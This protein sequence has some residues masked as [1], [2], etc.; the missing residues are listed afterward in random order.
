MIS[1]FSKSVLSTIQSYPITTCTDLKNS[2]NCDSEAEDVKSTCKLPSWLEKKDAYVPPKYLYDTYEKKTCCSDLTKV[3]DNSTYR[4]FCKAFSK[5]ANGSRYSSSPYYVMPHYTGTMGYYNDADL[6]K[7]LKIKGNS[8][9]WVVIHNIKTG[10]C[11]VVDENYKVWQTSSDKD[12]TNPPGI[13][14][15]TLIKSDDIMGNLYE[16]H[17]RIGVGG[18]LSE[19]GKLTT[20]FPKITPDKQTMTIEF[21]VHSGTK[22]VNSGDQVI[23]IPFSTDSKKYFRKQPSELPERHKGETTYDFVN[24]DMNGEKFNYY[25]N[26]IGGDN[27]FPS[28]VTSFHSR[29]TPGIQ[30]WLRYETKNRLMGRMAVSS[31]NAPFTTYDTSPLFWESVDS[32]ETSFSEFTKFDGWKDDPLKQFK[33]SLASGKMNYTIQE[34]RNLKIYYSEIKFY[35]KLNA[36]DGIFYRPVYIPGKTPLRQNNMGQIYQA[37]TTVDVDDGDCEESGC[38]H[39]I[40]VEIDFKNRKA[41]GF[42]NGSP[43][44]TG[45]NSI[46]F[47]KAQCSD[48]KFA[49]YNFMLTDYDP[50]LLN[51]GDTFVR[52]D[53]VEM[54]LAPRYESR[55]EDCFFPID[56]DFKEAYAMYM[57]SQ[58]ISDETAIADLN[59]TLSS[60]ELGDLPVT[61]MFPCKDSDS[62]DVDQKPCSES[63]FP[64]DTRYCLG[65]SRSEYKHFPY[66]VGDKDTGCNSNAYKGCLDATYSACPL[67]LALTCQNAN[68]PAPKC[69]L[70][71]GKNKD[72]VDRYGRTCADISNDKRYCPGSS[73][74]NWALFPYKKDSCDQNNYAG[75]ELTIL[76]ACTETFGEFC[77]DEGLPIKSC[78]FKCKDTNMVDRKNRDCSWLASKNDP[79][80]CKGGSRSTWYE[81]PLVEGKCKDSNYSGCEKTWSEMCPATM[82]TICKSAGLTVNDNINNCH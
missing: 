49:A 52:E 59:I 68:K 4:S 11:K 44:C 70:P 65:T 21:Y 23:E 53:G 28:G 9:D 51:V 78:T 69:L 34:A 57:G 13:C 27:F 81:G 15:R 42:L 74:E 20:L 64:K 82:H 80:Y 55:S 2:Y 58:S 16:P 8:R 61:T 41:R 50:P 3:F 47:G 26:G 46:C 71:C 32:N 31:E 72:V 39:K 45:R 35:H 10:L 43:I 37:K 14:D 73:R 56:D 19:S 60:D 54:T 7:P 6:M 29:R 67:T 30:L 33:D 40:K 24:D 17:V 77:R 62:L 12:P 5:H 36:S 79:R 25:E 18:H 22:G 48:P 63:K 38:E 76:D 75:C 1:T 66:K